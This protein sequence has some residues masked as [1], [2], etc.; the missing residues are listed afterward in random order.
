MEETNT[1]TQVPA[2]QNY[3]IPFAIVIAGLAIAGAIYFGGNNANP[4]A[5]A[6]PAGAIDPVTSADHI[7]GNPNAKLFVVEYSDTECPYCKTF[8]ATMNRIMNEYGKDG[9]VAWVYRQ[10]PIES[11]HPAKAQNEAE[12]TECA[13]KLGGNTKFWEYINKVFE[14]T[15]SNN[16]LDQAELPIIA[17]AIGLDVTEFN[18]CLEND[19]MK[20]VVDAQIASGAKA[21]VSGTPYSIILVNKKAVSGINGAQPYEVVKAQI[22][23]LLK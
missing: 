18:K 19:E 20:T 16:R 13:N 4:V 1:T 14:I 3:A 12:A 8:H 9:N 6:Q 21:G 10:F 22:E 11:L 15:P 17:K 7:I 2:S 5:A 23:E